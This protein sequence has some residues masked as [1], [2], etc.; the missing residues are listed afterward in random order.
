MGGLGY[1]LAAYAIVGIALAG[2]ALDLLRRARALRRELEA[3]NTARAR[4]P[5]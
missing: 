1:L 5:G 2:Y 4:R 3:A